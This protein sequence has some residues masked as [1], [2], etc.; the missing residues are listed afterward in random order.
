MLVR[1]KC[2]VSL[3]TGHAKP[4]LL[5][6]VPA[7]S[8]CAFFPATAQSPDIP[9]VQVSAVKQVININDILRRELKYEADVSD[10][11]KRIAMGQISQA[12]GS[13]AISV[14]LS[15]RSTGFVVGTDSEEHT[16]IFAG[17]VRQLALDQDH[18]IHIW[19][20][21]LPPAEGETVLVLD[22]Q[23]S[24][25]DHY[26]LPEASASPFLTQ[27][28]I[29]W[30]V[31]GALVNKNLFASLY[32]KADVSDANDKTS[33]QRVYVGALP[34]NE[35]F[36]TFG[37][38]TE[39]VVIHNRKGSV[40]KSYTAPLDSAYQALGMSFSRPAPPSESSRVLWAAATRAGLI[41]ICLAGTS[42]AGPAYIAVLDVNS[43]TI[44][45]IIQ[46]ELPRLKQLV[47]PRN[48]TGI[49]FPGRGAVDDRLIIADQRGFLA[50][51]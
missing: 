48:S 20:R 11:N 3:E 12:N 44:T 5:M 6:I 45:S 16:F 43:G 10:R 8:V 51:Y 18:N 28:G 21:T 39:G 40:I 1:K 23:G 35:G 22:W 36:F 24:V 33:G 4:N 9:A 15:P 46:A 27:T 2:G 31:P 13:W 47:S 42:A 19:Q 29:V 7:L 30:R 50:T 26:S 34:G 25:V 17:R 14:P 32:E 49:M 41:Y 38:M 37:D